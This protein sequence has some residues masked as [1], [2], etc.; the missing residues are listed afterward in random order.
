MP[1]NRPLTRLLTL[2]FL[3]AFLMAGCLGGDDP[4]PSAGNADPDGDAD[5][6]GDGT[7]DDGG[8]ADPDG[9]GDGSGDGDGEEATCEPMT[10]NAASFTHDGL[11]SPDPAGWDPSSDPTLIFAQ[12]GTET[13][14]IDNTTQMLYVTATAGLQVTL[15]WE[16]LLIDPAGTQQYTFPGGPGIVDNVTGSTDIADPLPGEWTITA[17][18]TGY[19]EG[20]VFNVD[21]ETCQ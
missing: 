3:L 17:T 7:G 9:D 10:D 13:F 16:V 20:L 21:A 1:F 11:A 2:A 12:N 6:D 8:D 14:T 15:G 18:I 19:V 5:D 4:D